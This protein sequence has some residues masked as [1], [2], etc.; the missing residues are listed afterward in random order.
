MRFV[1]LAEPSTR[2]GNFE[3][4]KILAAAAAR[5]LITGLLIPTGR[6]QVK[7]DLFWRTRLLLPAL[8]HAPDADE[9]KR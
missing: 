5:Y 4:V 8:Q 7:L 1:T 6:R 3:T 9:H 2:R